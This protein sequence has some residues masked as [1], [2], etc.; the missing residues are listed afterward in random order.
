MANI[1]VR[2]LGNI[3]MTA[4]I[5]GLVISAIIMS[6]GA[7][8]TATYLNL[9]ASSRAEAMVRLEN[10]LRTA[11]TVAGSNLPAAE[12]TWAEDG[13]LAALRTW[14]MPRIF[15]NHNL[16]DSI[17]NLTG[18]SATIY[19]AEGPGKPLEA[20]S[21][22][23]VGA[24]GARLVGGV[25]AA[26]DPAYETVM[27][28]LPYFGE[29]EIAGNS[30]YTAYQP[31]VNQQDEVI[32]VIYAGMDKAKLEAAI[33]DTLWV[34]LGVGAVCL[35]IL[36]VLGYA[37][38]RLITGSV[39]RLAQ[40]MKA[41][42]EGDYETAVPYVERRNEI[43]EMARAVE[44]FREN[45]LKVSAMTEEERAA[46]ERRRIERTDMM[47]ALQAAF[48]EVVDA[49]IA[50]DFSKRVH[51]QFPDEELN[52]LAGSVNALVE[53]VDRGLS[54]T[55]EVLAAMA[56]ADMTRRMEGDYQGSFAKLKADTNAVAEKLS[57]LIGG[58]RTTSR[59]LK[60]ATGEILS[61][62]NDLSERTTKQAATI[63]ETSAAMEQLANTVA[64][65]ARMADDANISANSVSADATRSGEVME[66]ANEAMER[67]TQS[68]A[69]ISN[70]I[71]MIDDIAF[72]TNLLALNASVEAARAGEAGKGFAVVAVEVRRLAQSAAE[73][74]SEV[75]ALI[76]ASASEV[77]TGSDLVSSAAG[78]LRDMLG[79]VT[80][81]AGLMQSIA[82]ASKA[83][84]AAIEEV[85]VAVRTLDE[86][87]QHNAALVEET[88]AAIEQT[89]AQA[90]ELDR[91]VDLFTIDAGSK[92]AAA[93]VAP[94][95]RLEKEKLRSAARSYLSQGNAAISADWS[96]F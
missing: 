95:P 6:I 53:T 90:S 75:K 5:A 82:K 54:E 73:A 1:F 46:A 30:Y 79:A 11:A 25:F 47:V 20:L 34:L 42:A 8:T 4:M 48:G 62:A 56:E 50:G 78:Q 87:T 66:R 67:I 29:A 91:V 63:E 86:M 83:Q 39:P 31:V 33:L 10:S 45:G 64:E 84:A 70:I 61:G 59:A 55:G 19:S 76:E 16:V 41:I 37:L 74:S 96:E 26:D 3:R 43:G 13:S 23:L 57:E 38:S 7:V 65:N 21:S 81:N 51:A 89:E 27:S 28:G 22:T 15:V 71:G 9:S 85:S 69:K 32:G 14:A 88:N 18:E 60:T 2:F 94:P 24:D 52:S 44:V 17:A 68:S 36:G 92:P 77:K 93:P 80:E 12:V 72:Q 40:T 35:A 58:L 49:A